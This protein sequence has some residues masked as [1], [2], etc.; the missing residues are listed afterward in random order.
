MLEQ[1]D[2]VTPESSMGHMCISAKSFVGPRGT[3][4]YL[5]I[6]CSWEDLSLAPAYITF[7]FIQYHSWGT[8]L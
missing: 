1:K 5:F 4:F 7:L 6:L 8:A 3:H 2:V